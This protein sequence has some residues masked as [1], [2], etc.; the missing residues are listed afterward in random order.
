[1]RG[2]ILQDEGVILHCNAQ[3]GGLS[4]QGVSSELLEQLKTENVKPLL[5]ICDCDVFL[6]YIAVSQS[7]DWNTVLK[8]NNISPGNGASAKK[9]GSPFYFSY[10]FGRMGRCWNH[11]I[12]CYLQST[13][14][15][16]LPTQ[17]TCFN[18]QIYLMSMLKHSL[19]GVSQQSNS[20]IIIWFDS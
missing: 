19:F 20:K 1:M 8:V 17:N 14:L 9:C 12:K 3:W 13:R 7:F 16:W 15:T 4:W 10:H 6:D 18:H 2:V 11:G 5:L